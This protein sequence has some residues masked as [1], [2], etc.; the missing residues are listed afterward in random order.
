MRKQLLKH[1]AHPGS[2]MLL[3]LGLLI[4]TNYSSTAQ[5]LL[6]ESFSSQMLPTGWDTVSVT[7][8]GNWAFDNPGGRT[9][10]NGTNANFDT[11]FAIFDSDDWCGN[12]EDAELITPAFDASGTGSV[13]L[14]FDNS[15]RNFG[16]Q[17]GHVEVWNGTVWTDVLTLSGSSD[18][19][20]DANR[21]AIDIT[22]AAGGST[23]AK[24]RFHWANGSCDWWWA[25]DNVLIEIVTCMAPSGLAVSNET[26]QSADLSWTAP[27]PAPANG[28][29]YY[30][31]QTPVPPTASST[32][33]GT[34][35]SG[36]TFTMPS[37]SSATDYYVWLRADCGAGDLSSWAGGIPFTT[38]C[39]GITAPYTQD[40]DGG[41]L[42]IC[43]TNT[44]D[45]SSTVAA[46]LWKF[47]GAPGWNAANNG[48][49][50]GTFAWVDASSPYPDSISL[51]SAILDLTALTVPYLEFEFFSNSGSGSSTY[52]NN[53]FRVEAYDGTA[54]SVLFSSNTSDPNWRKIGVNLSVNTEQVRFVV[55]KSSNDFYDD[56]LLDNIVIK[57][58]PNCLEPLQLAAS[59]IAASGLD[60]SWTAPSPAPSNGYAYYYNT[61]GASPSA[62]ATP[63]GTVPSGTTATLS[64]LTGN[65]DYYIWLRSDC[66]TAD[67]NSDWAGP[68]IATTLPDAQTPATLPWSEDFTSGGTDWTILNGMEV[69]QWAVGSATGNTGNSLYVTEDN[70]TTNTYDNGES[71]V[72]FAYRDVEVPTGAT[73]VVLSFDWKAVGESNWDYLRVW[74]IGTDQV[75]TPGTQITSSNTTGAEQV[76]GSG[77]NGNFNVIRGGTASAWI[78]ENLIL[79]ASSVAGDTVRLVFE[80]RNDGGAGSQPPAG[81]DNIHVSVVTCTA[82]EDPVLSSVSHNAAVVSWDPSVPAP[83]DGYDYYYSTSSTAPAAGTTIS[84]NSADTFAGLSGLTPQTDYYVWLRS[85]CGSTDGKSIWS[86]PLQ[87]S[88]LPAPQ[89]PAT[90]PW[91]E[92]FTTSGA[93]WTL[94]NGS[95]YNQWVVAAAVGNTGNS[96]YISE[97]NG[98]SYTYDNGESSIVFA[99]RD[100]AI[101][102]GLTYVSLSFDWQAVAEGGWDYLR[103]WAIPA[104][105]VPAP[106]TAITTTNTTGALQIGGSGAAGNFDEDRGGLANTWISESMMVDVSAFAGS[107]LRLVMQWRNDGSFGDQPPAA[108]DNLLLEAPSCSPPGQV[109]YEDIQAT[110]IDISWT[111][112]PT[113]ATGG[114]DYYYDQTNTAP[115][116]T[117]TPNGNFA[118]AAVDGTISSLTPNTTY[119][120]WIRSNCGSGDES[121]WISAGSFTT[122]CELPTLPYLEGFDNGIAPDCWSESKGLLGSTVTFTGTTAAWTEHDWLTSGATDHAAAINLFSNTKTDWLISP[123]F[124]LGTAGNYI[125]EFD[126]AILDWTSWTDEALGLDDT[127]A[128]VI[129]TDGGATWSNSNILEFWTATNT[130]LTGGTHI[131]IP[132]SNYTGV[133]K[134]GFYGSEGTSN[135]PEDNRVQINNFEIIPCTAPALTI[136]AGSNCGPG[137]ISLSASASGTGLEYEWFD[138]ASGGTAIGTGASF[139]TPVIS[140]TTTYYVEVSEN[141]CTSAR[142]AV[143]ATIHALPVVDL[144]ADVAICEGE[145]SVLDATGTGL[146]YAWDDNSTQATRTVSAAGTYSVTVTDNNQCEDRDTIVVTV[147]P[148]PL[149]DLGADTTICAVTP[150]VL[151]AGNAGADYIWSDGSSAQTLS[152]AAAGTYWAEV[153]DAATGCVGSDTIGVFQENPV[154]IAGIDMT[155]DDGNGTY[156]FIASEV[157]FAV[158]IYWD[159]GDGETGTGVEVTHTYASVGT[160][161]VTA[162]GVGDCG[163]S[164]SVSYTLEYTVGIDDIPEAKNL[165]IYPNPSRDVFTIEIKQGASMRSLLLYNVLGQEVYRSPTDAGNWHS[166][167]A[168]SL[169]SGIYTL[170]IDTD[171]GLIIRKIEVLR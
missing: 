77:N 129:S 83:A 6:S 21:K 141:G 151:D 30:V 143:E 108:V 155:A 131:S 39:A 75:P 45:G 11:S 99:Y 107:T 20:A 144:G 167:S 33:T 149:V 163:D 88:T 145:S 69:N 10:D 137:T 114:Y 125:L 19:Y 82:P 24:V 142:E 156:G 43:W 112:P 152:V 52:A 115:T 67:G 13:L 63:N 23:A 25:I 120:L 161:I 157:E 40:L 44:N 135:D 9:I 118:S 2:L 111:A 28:Y 42:P 62:S 54:W 93:D 122:I 79:D 97:D 86:G 150:L 15:F 65:T 37:L 162:T 16:S 53:D 98:V 66:G 109:A 159:F 51:T 58:A 18:G 60:I 139:T 106:G 89:T 116:S 31:S 70:G 17:Q 35:A 158:A 22:A 87:F 14:S 74:V 76:G 160:Y 72:V 96:L 57:E 103:V 127:L 36:T 27:S 7:N 34:I 113:V 146:T 1:A 132:L 49:A 170:K 50:A 48:R 12:T 126:L 168:S 121:M 38:L 68:V 169:A 94:L 90:L 47:S 153:T 165:I 32:P 26:G 134:I 64:G 140:T 119:Y 29:Q 85:D 110:S 148:L 41:N 73:E 80:W 4:G 154:D 138:V 3:F 123:Q 92:D 171:K 78:S 124:D 5:T 8:D 84:G 101:P 59:N 100:I 147:N 81:V 128:V 166:L 71:S 104:T 46:A 136:T 130:P 117:T 55:D 61:T 105:E 95:E 164:V 56:I 91:S 102:S 133:V